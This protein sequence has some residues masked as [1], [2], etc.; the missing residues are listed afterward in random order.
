MQKRHGSLLYNHIADNIRRYSTAITLYKR[1]LKKKD[2][3]ADDAAYYTMRLQEYQRD[4]DEM[5]AVIE[6]MDKRYDLLN[7][8]CNDSVNKRHETTQ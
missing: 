2:L 8:T 4:L 7:E 1:E 5:V 3:N 6:F